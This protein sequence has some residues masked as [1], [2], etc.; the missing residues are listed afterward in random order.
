MFVKNIWKRRYKHSIVIIRDYS[1][2]FDAL[3]NPVE[4]TKASAV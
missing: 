1:D 4:L 3:L 2:A